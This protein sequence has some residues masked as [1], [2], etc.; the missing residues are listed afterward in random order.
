MQNNL[1]LYQQITACQGTSNSLTV[2]A[3]PK[4]PAWDTGSEQK[5]RGKY[6]MLKGLNWEQSQKFGFFRYCY[7]AK[8]GLIPKTSG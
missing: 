7:S 6:Y 4:V 8:C 5:I 2:D 3:I 1:E